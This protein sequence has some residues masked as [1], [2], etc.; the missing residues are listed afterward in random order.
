MMSFSS[1]YSVL[2]STCAA[3]T[4]CLKDR[5]DWWWLWDLSTLDLWFLKI[6][7]LSSPLDY[8]CFIFL[9]VG[10][11]IVAF[12]SIRSSSLIF[13]PG[14]SNRVLTWLCSLIETWKSRVSIR[15]SD[16]RLSIMRRRVF[17]SI[18]KFFFFSRT[19]LICDLT[20]TSEMWPS[21]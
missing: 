16:L 5:D 12:T 17:L 19:C 1:A 10:F 4:S 15:P 3:F 13:K 2:C 14:L 6:G 20:R 9:F 7:S 11:A 18:S 8:S 21:S